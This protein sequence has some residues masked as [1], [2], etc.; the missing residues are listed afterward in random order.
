MSEYS[1]AI[2]S[3]FSEWAEKSE[4][5]IGGTPIARNHFIRDGIV[6]ENAWQ[7]V[8]P[9]KH[10]LFVLKE[11][12]DPNPTSDWTIQELLSH[13]AK[14]TIWRRVA[15][16][17][18]GIMLTDERG[19]FVPYEEFPGGNGTHDWLKKIAVLNLKK[20]SG[21]N[22]ADMSKIMEYAKADAAEIRR[23]ITLIDPDI[24]VCGGT[25]NELFAAVGLSD[26]EEAMSNFYK[27]SY[28]NFCGRKRLL[29]DYYHP[30]NRYPRVLNY[31]G[32]TGIYCHA[33]QSREDKT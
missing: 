17:T 18:R 25:K 3:L 7:Q 1:D 21:S 11:V 4:I 9:G 30:A 12:N 5:V 32:I 22:S 10:I 31:Y 26:N 29:I 16:W 6:D 23:E 15:E 28:I 8:S 27:Y 19:S 2:R 14:Y 24:V 13:D 20:T 33:C